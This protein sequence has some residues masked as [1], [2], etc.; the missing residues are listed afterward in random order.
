MDDDDRR[1]APLERGASTQQR[2]FAQLRRLVASPGF[3]YTLA[4]VAF[5]DFFLDQMRDATAGEWQQRLSADELTLVSGLAAAHGI[6]VETIPGPDVQRRQVEQLRTLLWE[7][8]QVVRKPIEERM[9][10]QLSSPTAVL[11]EGRDRNQRFPT[12]ADMVEPIF[13]SGLGAH[14]FQYLELAYERYWRDADWL[15][16]NVELSIDQLAKV[17]VELKH[18]REM[19]ADAQQVVTGHVERCLAELAVLSFR[20]RDLSF[21]TDRQFDSFVERF[22]TVPGELKF[23]PDTVGAMNDLEFKPIVR[24]GPDRYFMPSGFHLAKSVYD[25]PCFWMRSDPAYADR[26]DAHRGQAAEEIATRLLE[27]VFGDGVYRDVLVKEGNDT[28]TDIDVFSR[29]RRQGAGS[30]GQIEATH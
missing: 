14:D 16:E 11:G 7:L 28:V 19:R 10:S 25:N 3:I 22:V 9:W 30:A 12:A 29:C 26:A 17:A 21:L 1:R 4:H 5:Q 13:Y 24:I 2:I 20:R 8:Q 15:A 18:L 23:V 6:Y 27:S